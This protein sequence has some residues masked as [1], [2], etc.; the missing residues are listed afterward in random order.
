[1]S[2]MPANA[3]H[4]IQAAL[5][6]LFVFLLLIAGE[7]AV[8]TM[9]V[10]SLPTDLYVYPARHFDFYRI[11]WT[12]NAWET[13]KLLLVDKA[14]LIVEHRDTTQGIQVWGVFYYALGLAIHGVVALLLG[15]MWT[16]GR[17]RTTGPSL[18][19]FALGA[20]LLIFATSYA[21][22]ASCCGAGPGWIVDVWLLSRVYDSL[23]APG[24]QDVY[25]LVEGLFG[26][27][28]LLLATGGVVLMIHGWT[29]SRN[30]LPDPSS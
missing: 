25:Q 16:T 18:W 10:G 20:M 21:R 30:R 11:L 23:G 13:I 4:I 14:V 5:A 29:R 12:S 7:V 6:G 19:F 3:Y 9:L 2:P 17:V 1:M 28:Q 22:L 26:F 27:T 24:W 15:V 8:W